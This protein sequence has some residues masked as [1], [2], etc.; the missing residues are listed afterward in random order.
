MKICV[1]CS[2]SNAV[3]NIYFDGA[4]QLG[5]LIAQNKYQLVYGGANVGLMNEVA[6]SVSFNGAKIT[7]VIP[8]K[9]H[10]FKLSTN[11]ANDLIITETMTERKNTMKKLYD[12]FI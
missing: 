11:L 5:E 8:R 1:F 7:G 4:R 6:K 3:D 9:I 2:S 12:I 10:D